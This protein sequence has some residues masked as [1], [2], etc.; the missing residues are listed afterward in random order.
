MLRPAGRL[1]IADWGRPAK[2]LLRASFLVLQILDGSTVPATT[3]PGASPNS[4]AA[5]A[6]ATST[7]T[8]VSEPLGERLA[9]RGTQ[10]QLITITTCC[11]FR[12]TPRRVP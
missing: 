2:P 11:R 1:H 5:P 7:S 10:E 8:G 9:A 6:S 3:P 4:S 12:P